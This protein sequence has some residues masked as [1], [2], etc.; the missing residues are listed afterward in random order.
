MSLLATNAGRD[1]PSRGRSPLTRLTRPCF[2]VSLTHRDYALTEGFEPTSNTLTGCCI[3]IMLHE[4]KSDIVGINEALPPAIGSGTQREGI[5][6]LLY[7]TDLTAIDLS[8]TLPLAHR[9]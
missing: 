7:Q 5:F 4:N 6:L 9:D 2:G 8:V 3:T 1:A